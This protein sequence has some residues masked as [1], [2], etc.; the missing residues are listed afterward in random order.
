MP[1]PTVGALTNKNQEN[2]LYI[3]KAPR[4]GDHYGAKS[5]NRVI[6]TAAAENHP[7]TTLKYIIVGK[8]FHNILDPA[9]ENVAQPVHGVGFNVLV[10]LQTV[11]QGAVNIIMCVQVVLCN[12]PLL[13]SLP[14][15]V[16]ANHFSAPMKILL[17]FSLLSQ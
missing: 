5:K 8:V 9:V 11:Y 17:D 6:L 12:A 14:K 1:P 3:N 16:I 4:R 10:V 7:V 2:T 13:H 15:P